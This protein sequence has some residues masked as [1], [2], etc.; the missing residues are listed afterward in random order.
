MPYTNGETVLPGDNVKN[1]VEQPGTVTR[2]RVAPNGDDF[3]SIR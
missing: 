3:V 1:N 2:V